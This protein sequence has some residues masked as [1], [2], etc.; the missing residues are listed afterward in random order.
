LYALDDAPPTLFVRGHWEPLSDKTVA[1]VG[2]R[3]PSPA[4][5]QVAKEL[6]M[7]LAERGYTIVSGLAVGIDAAAHHGALAVA[8]HT[9]AVLG[10]GVLNVY[11]PQHQDLAEAIQLRGALLSEVQPF[12]E[13]N[14]S[15]LVARNRIITG[16]SQQVIVVE[17][18]TDGGAMHAA[19]FAGLQ[20]RRLYTLDLPASGNRALLA[21]GATGIRL[22]LRDLPF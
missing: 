1:I 2:T 8:G 16:L 14:A 6:S 11:P 21:N 15:A 4:A 19:R 5:E 20:R 12:A 22:D 10:S 13:T 9:L 17:T 18:A 7:E 3:E